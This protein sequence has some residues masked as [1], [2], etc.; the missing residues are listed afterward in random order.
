MKTSKSINAKE[1]N[2][3]IDPIELLRLIGH[4]KSS[5]KESN[6]EIRDYCPI[7][8]GDHQRS[9]SINKKT[10]LYKCHSCDEAGT[11]IHLYSKSRGYDFPE[12]I[13]ELSK[14]FLPYPL[15]ENGKIESAIK[16]TISTNT[17]VDLDKTWNSSETLGTHKYFSQ[18]RITTPLGVR[19][20]KDQKG[21]DSI[22]VPFT[23][24]NGS[25]Q[26]LQYINE[27]GIKIFLKGSKVKDH[28]FS[29]GEI[30]DGST[31]YIAEGL[32]TATTTWEALGK[33]IT[34][35]SAG[36]VGNIPNVVRVIR[37]KHPNVSI[38]L[39]IDNNEA[40][41][42]ILEKIPTPFSFTCPNFESLNLPDSEKK[43][44]DFNDLR[45]VGNLP[46]DEIK[47]QLLE[48]EIQ[49][50]PED[51]AKRLGKIIGNYEYAKKLENLSF[52]SFIA[53]HKETVSK[54]GL[55]LGF[56]KVDKEVYFTKGSFVTIQAPSNHGKSTFMLQMAYRFLSQDKN[57]KSDAM[58][59]FIT[60]ESSPFKVQEKFLRVI[61]HEKGEGIPIKYN[62]DLE[63]KYLYP[64]EEDFQKTIYSFNFL[65]IE[66]KIQILEPVPLENL[67][68][69]I[70]FYKQQYPHRTIVLILDYI[71]IITTSKTGEPWKV[72][73]DVAHELQQLAKDKKIII[74]TG[75]QVNDK[76]QTREGR[77]IYHA[78]TINIAFTNRSHPS[79][80]NNPDTKNSYKEPIDGKGVCDL[81]VQKNK[82]GSNFILYE[83]LLFN[84]HFFEESKVER[85]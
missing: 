10:H 64:R 58:C 30:K 83:Y 24:I 53:E 17:P 51:F 75:S 66:K 11:L 12:A 63:E 4:E 49:K 36:S 47:R 45:S 16:T 14:Q 18:K 44:D 5:P 8:I 56:E 54:G 7:H 42:K 23:D 21:N 27:Q 29:L 2:E 26:A 43:I 62:N 40:A 79:I 59:I 65:A 60:Y 57:K 6:G 82:D 22:V 76:G 15:K 13:E 28:F 3:K 73:K 39:A 55:L 46:L 33:S 68:D 70:N 25:L 71:Q 35:L 9:L 77:D 50:N 19:F 67:D 61:S 48:N 78:S 80:K 52:A 20:G 38:K 32:A 1:L 37:E 69:L 31:I 85:F 41:K 74:V 84:G 81:W 72:M 34:V